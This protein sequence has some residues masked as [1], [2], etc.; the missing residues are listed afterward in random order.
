MPNSLDT[1][2]FSDSTE[3]TKFHTYCSFSQPIDHEIPK[4][5]LKFIPPHPPPPLYIPRRIRQSTPSSPHIPKF[6]DN[7]PPV[8][9]NTHYGPTRPITSYRKQISTPVLLNML[10]SDNRS[11]ISNASTSLSTTDRTTSVSD[12]SSLVGHESVQH[13]HVVRISRSGRDHTD[14]ESRSTTPEFCRH[15]WKSN[16]EHFR[17]I[18][19]LGPI[20]LH[21][22]FVLLWVGGT[23]AGLYFLQNFIWP[24]NAVKD[25]TWS[26]L[27][28]IWLIP[29]PSSLAFLTGA[30]CFRYA[31][32]LDRVQKIDHNVAFRIVSRGINVDCLLATIRKCQKEMRHTPMFPYLIEV[33]TDGDQFKAPP[34]GDVVHLK[35]PD[36]Y[37]TPN[38]SKFKARALH[39]ACEFSLLP[40]D[41]WIVHLDEESQITSSVIKG[42]AKMV[43]QCEASGNIERIGQGMI[44][45]H[46]NWRKHPFLTLADMR[47]TGDDLGH[48][49]L[50]HSLGYTIFGLHGSFV[51]VRQDAEARIGFDVG[52]QG[53]ITEDAWWV[54]LAIERGYRTMWCDGYLEEQA[55]QGLMDFLKQRRRWY[56]GL[57]KVG[58]FCPVKI[59]HRVL[60]MLNTLSWV[61]LPLYLPCSFAY[62]GLSFAFEKQ[63]PLP[64]RLATNLIFSTTT[65]VYLS[66]LVINMR[67][68]GTPWWRGIFWISLEL[69]LLPVFFLMEVASIV[70]VFLSPFSKTASKGFHVVVKSAKSKTSSST[71]VT[72]IWSGAKS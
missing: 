61:V 36:H 5:D 41:T 14:L 20:T 60:L 21:R 48:F 10:R 17:D 26:L 32:K 66:G 68:H 70:L 27:G 42:V 45:Y 37:Q 22:I 51:V 16:R 4:S 25:R 15:A 49:F 38:R 69:I 40:G 8:T 29:L 43:S 47:R 44:L 71:A 56:V 33:V 59:R 19:F 28:I 3:V 7:P 6:P 62:L 50:Q 12:S 23:G 46:R 18:D 67:E 24:P 52:P 54:L 9:T 39:Y 65:L 1:N 34:D 64:I 35:V 13:Q 2:P 30:L 72:S 11:H 53:S 57:W 63:I 31:T 58:L 55:T